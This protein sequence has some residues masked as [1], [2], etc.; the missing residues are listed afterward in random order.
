M[1][2]IRR[3]GPLRVPALA[4]IAL[5]Y[6]PL[7][8]ICPPLPG[9]SLVRG[10][11]DLTALTEPPGGISW[12]ARTCATFFFAYLALGVAIVALYQSAAMIHDFAPARLDDPGSPVEEDWLGPRRKY[13]YAFAG[14]PAAALAIL[15]SLLVSIDPDGVSPVGVGLGALVALLAVVML[16]WRAVV[17]CAS[18]RPAQRKFFRTLLNRAGVRVA[19]YGYTATDAVTPHI[20]PF[21]HH[22]WAALFLL[23]S[24]LVWIIVGVWA[25]FPSIQPYVR[26]PALCSLY[27]LLM[28][29][30]WG[31]SS[32]TFFLDYYRIPILTM[33]LVP[34]LSIGLRGYVYDATRAEPQA[35]PLLPREVVEGRL[36]TPAGRIVAISAAGGG[37]QAAAWTARILQGLVE[38]AADED[39]N[40]FLERIVVLSGVSGGS[41]GLAPFALALHADD[42]ELLKSDQITS[43]AGTSSLDRVAATWATLDMLPFRISTDRGLAL[44]NAWAARW[45]SIGLPPGKRLSEFTEAGG[46]PKRLRAPGI[47]FNATSMTT[48]ERLILGTTVPTVPRAS[49]PSFMQSAVVERGGGTRS[50]EYRALTVAPDLELA[51]AARLSA[52]F[53]LVSPAA[54]CRGCEGIDQFVVDGGYIDNS[55]VE[56]MAEWLEALL[57]DSDMGA[58]GVTVVQIIPFSEDKCDERAHNQRLP[59]QG[60]VPLTTLY[61]IRGP[62]QARRSIT[63]LVDLRREFKS[64]VCLHSFVYDNCRDEQGFAPPLSWHLTSGQME[65][66]RAAWDDSDVAEARQVVREALAED[67]SKCIGESIEASEAIGDAAATEASPSP[68]AMTGAESAP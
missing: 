29:A 23:F 37:I 19:T 51:T 2:L 64:R 47:M 48:G 5:I 10:L 15:A 14:L 16:I 9:S 31:L 67:V 61:A 20:D 50:P 52:T 49:R 35:A 30:T 62:G 28:L 32:L 34:T 39:M 3:I 60:A 63:D 38:V 12:L 57:S 22:V 11:F 65:D 8:A 33:L 18:L 42:R 44:Q 17:A 41:V 4:A 43:A 55:G 66:I 13:V 24:A 53:P 58:I 54:H 46:E 1:I 26:V 21:R 36:G 25:L 27:L 40:R 59:S 45:K 7:A 6:L 56:S 68:E